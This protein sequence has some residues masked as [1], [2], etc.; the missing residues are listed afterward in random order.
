[1]SNVI[2]D[3]EFDFQVET[4]D[5]YKIIQTICKE[6]NI[7]IK[8]NLSFTPCCWLCYY[9]TCPNNI[10]SYDIGRNGAH[11]DYSMELLSFDKACIRLNKNDRLLT[12]NDSKLCQCDIITIMKTGCICDGI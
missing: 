10:G 12:Q 8:P 5:Q 7:V 11:S 1:M 6:N 9:G 4:I 2:Y 3:Y